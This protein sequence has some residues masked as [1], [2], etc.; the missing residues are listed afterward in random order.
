MRQKFVNLFAHYCDKYDYHSVLGG[1]GGDRM[2][3]TN[4]DIIVNMLENDG[5]F[6]DKSGQ[7]DPQMALI[8]SYDNYGRPHFAVFADAAHDDMHMSPYVRN[9]KLLW[10]Q[11]E[12]LTGQGAAWLLENGGRL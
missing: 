12:G 3:Y 11:R 7:A 1:R 2:T 8:Y 6:V 4:S 5:V 9:A 10:S